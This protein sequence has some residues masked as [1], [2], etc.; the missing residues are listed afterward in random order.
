MN[1]EFLSGERG[2]ALESDGEA[3]PHGDSESAPS[4]PSTPSTPPLETAPPG[5][6]P[7]FLPRTLAVVAGMALLIATRLAFVHGDP[8]DFP[9]DRN[10]ASV[11][12]V[13]QF[14]VEIPSYQARPDWETFKTLIRPRPETPE[15]PLVR[16]VGW[17][18][19]ALAL[20]PVV[21][22]R[23]LALA[24][25]LLTGIGILV[26]GRRASPE[27]YAGEVALAFFA[28]APL[29]VFMGR[30]LLP[31]SPMLAAVVWAIVAAGTGRRGVHPRAAAWMAL[32]LIAAALLKLP[33]LVFAPMAALGYMDSVGWR[34]RGAWI[35]LAL[36][37]LA[38][39][40]AVCVWYRLAPWNPLPGLRE[41]SSNTNHMLAATDVALGRP[42]LE[43]LATR[44]V[45]ALT[46]IGLLMALGGWVL[47][48]A[49]PGPR[50]WLNAIW[51]FSLFFVLITIGANTY[52]AYAA[53]PAGC[54]LAALAAVELWRFNRWSA[55]AAALA[56]A[57][58]LPIDP[59][60]RQV[61]HYLRLEPG[62]ARLGEAGRDL[63]RE[64]GVIQFGSQWG[65]VAW[66]TG[67]RGPVWIDSPD[68]LESRTWEN[69]RYL[70]TARMNGDPMLE[71]LFGLK[72]VV[73]TE[74]DRFMIFRVEAGARLG[75]AAP[76][77]G[78]FPGALDEPIEL[79]GARLVAL[80]AEP[81]EA[82]P[83]ESIRI[84]AVFEP[85]S[86]GTP[87]A[88]APLALKLVHE[89]TGLALA[90][91]PRAGGGDFARW[92]WPRVQLPA[93]DS[94]GP[95]RISYHYDLPPLMPA[96]QYRV[97]PVV[98]DGNGRPDSGR[99]PETTPV[100]LTVRPAPAVAAPLALDVAGALWHQPTRWRLAAWRGRHRERLRLQGESR[101]WMAPALEAGRYRLAITARADWLGDDPHTRWPV[102]AVGRP[103]S[104]EST[105]VEFNSRSPR[106]RV[107]ELD[108]EGPGD[109]LVMHIHNAGIDYHVRTPF[110]LYP[111]QLSEGSRLIEFEEIRV[112][113]TR[114]HGPTRTNTD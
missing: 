24:T 53:V 12:Q 75:E 34:R 2:R 22:M 32:F 60:L 68:L 46:G 38:V 57:V 65:D 77:D 88:P 31:D 105:L 80:A 7:R 27:T 78:A 100:V 110:A 41:I 106:R 5:K 56:A 86:M 16:L 76:T 44:M 17:T 54:L 19:D 63:A 71:Q 45:L 109:M 49:R 69:N 97:R 61:S 3:A 87:G 23:L 72:P 51:L 9:L 18:A 96:G 1:D 8:S 111:N 37:A 114:T 94:G 101:L 70:F 29:S 104:G 95:E 93:L 39:Y 113:P 74:R 6:P 81:A 91:S 20:D 48:Q 102:L 66:F 47:V 35:G 4:A 62:Y 55:G 73:R 25:S 84:D 83:G 10:I 103:L 107:I 82:A 89:P 108:W 14:A 21:A 58:L 50:L 30:T 67:A 33:A 28:V 43:L 79:A 98:L 85:P 59:G 52:W 64:G 15:F 36:A 92:P 99:E 112:L 26:L 40:L 90:P 11:H 42:G 13:S